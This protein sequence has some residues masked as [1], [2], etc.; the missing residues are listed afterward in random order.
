MATAS[1]LSKGLHLY[2]SFATDAKACP[3]C[4]EIWQYVQRTDEE[5]L[6][7]ILDHLKQH[8]AKGA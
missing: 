7:R 3:D 5:R 2:G 1:V 4:Q 8:L 6:K